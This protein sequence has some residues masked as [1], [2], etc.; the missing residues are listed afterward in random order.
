M[1]YKPGG[2]IG[3]DLMKPI[4][5]MRCAAVIA[6]VLLQAA[7]AC[8][9]K[10]EIVPDEIE[11]PAFGVLVGYIQIE[12][13]EAKPSRIGG[14]LSRLTLEIESPDGT[15]TRLA[16]NWDRE[17]VHNP[18]QFAELNQGD[19]VR[20]PLCLLKSR[21]GYIF[22]TPGR[23]RI[24]AHYREIAIQKVASDDITIVETIP[25]KR[26]DSDW[27]EIVVGPPRWGRPNYVNL[28]PWD[29]LVGAFRGGGLGEIQSHLD[30]CRD[31][32][33]EQEKLLVYQDA[34]DG[35]WRALIHDRVRDKQ[36]LYLAKERLVRA[37]RVGA[38]RDMWEWIVARL[39][40]LPTSA[41]AATR[42]NAR[43]GYLF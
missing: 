32:R 43:N 10:L 26:G 36:V 39:E 42:L 24:R 29:D 15:R 20:N 33:H 16:P 14:S 4:L 30:D 27:V 35:L 23:Y 5:P 18:R 1:A 3:Q 11:I 40:E 17:E 25:G 12:N 2:G 37:K 13:V 38:G 31:Y 8:A 21:G 6:A 34:G 22:E 41:D 7:T 9:L 19:W 28:H